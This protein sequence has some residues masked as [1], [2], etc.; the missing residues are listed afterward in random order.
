MQNREPGV[1][2]GAAPPLAAA[3]PPRGVGAGRM[4]RSD[5]LRSGAK[6]GRGSVYK[7]PPREGAKASRTEYV[8]GTAGFNTFFL[9]PAKHGKKMRAHGQHIH[10]SDRLRERSRL[11]VFLLFCKEKGFSAHPLGP[12]AWIILA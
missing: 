9:R 7:G 12:S 8:Y 2:A 4:G 11:Q 1:A 10:R 6:W 5:Q 3:A